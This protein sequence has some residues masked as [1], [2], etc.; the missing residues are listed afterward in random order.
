M[1]ICTKISKVDI[2]VL[3]GYLQRTKLTVK[4]KSSKQVG[5]GRGRGRGRGRE[6]ESNEVMSTQIIAL[7]F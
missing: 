1:H 2:N 5:E 7:K 3:N 4:L 6:R